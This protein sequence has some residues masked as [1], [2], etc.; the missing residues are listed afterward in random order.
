MKSFLFIT[1]I[2]IY[3]FWRWYS[4]NKDNFIEWSASVL[5]KDETQEMDNM[6]K[7]IIDRGLVSINCK[8]WEVSDTLK[9]KSGIHTYNK[10]ISRSQEPF[11][12]I[13]MLGQKMHLVTSKKYIDEILNNSPH[14]FTVGKL[15]ESF[16]KP[17]MEH[18]VGVSTGCEWVKRRRINEKALGT[19]IEHPYANIF[20]E[21]IKDVVF[22]NNINDFSVAARKI[23]TKIVFGVEGD[24]HPIFEFLAIANSSDLKP[25]TSKKDKKARES[26]FKYMEYHIKNPQKGSLLHTVSESNCIELSH[27]I[28]HWVFPIAS[29]IAI[30]STRLLLL[31]SNHPKKFEK[32]INEI[33]LVYTHNGDSIYKLK[34]LRKC[35]LETL[36]INNNVV[37]MFRTLTCDYTF[38][39][40]SFKKGTQFAILTNP[41]LRSKKYFNEPNKFIP[42][43][44]NLKLENDSISF[45]K[46]P[47]KCP[48]KDLAIFITSSFIVNYLSKYG[49]I[50]TKLIDI[51]NIDH[52]INPCTIKITK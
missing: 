8:W 12:P 32:V 34:Y 4:N 15:K 35:I 50:K 38:D 7:I 52:A 23:A 16:F 45:S 11:I 21:Y 18:N 19:S 26:Y 44:W 27:Q 49:R 9:D 3:L 22:T 41:V 13:E 2:I 20:N 30:T 42:E 29:S 25:H 1:F 39:K 43:R 47:Q 24:S 5:N 17:F 36:R 31:L 6:V 40:Y 33:N 51:N 37:S 14:T 28:P 46:G 48:G 10:L